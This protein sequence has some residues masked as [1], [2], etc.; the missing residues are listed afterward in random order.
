MPRSARCAPKALIYHALN[1]AVASLLRFQKDADFAASE[2]VLHE[3]YAK[4]PLE[5]LAYC[6]MPNHWHFVLR[7]RQD[8]QL[9]AFLRWLT[10]TL[11]AQAHD[12]RW[13]SLWRRSSCA[14]G[15]PS[16][17]VSAR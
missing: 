15:V 1:R 13:S 17:R 16:N 10:H 3:A 4:F 5:T 2:R 12:W 7:P 6:V 9:T 8:G 11:V 14:A